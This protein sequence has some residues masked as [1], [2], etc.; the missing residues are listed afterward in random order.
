[1]TVKL[2]GNGPILHGKIIEAGV[3][4]KVCLSRANEAASRQQR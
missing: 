2:H 1:M 3:Y 4:N